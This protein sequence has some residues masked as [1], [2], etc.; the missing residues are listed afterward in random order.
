MSREMGLEGVGG[1]R[2]R[3]EGKKRGATKIERREK[4]NSTVCREARSV[5]NG[6]A[7]YGFLDVE[8]WGGWMK[9]EEI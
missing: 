3:R 1:R 9:S 7:N 5:T 2:Q 6:G 8:V 4:K